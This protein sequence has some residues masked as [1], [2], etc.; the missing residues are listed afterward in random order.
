VLKCDACSKEITESEMQVKSGREVA[1]KTKAGF[2]PSRI[3]GGV[4][5]AF[6]RSRADIW[7]DTV[8]R[9]AT[10]EWG[11]CRDCYGQLMAFGS[12][13]PHGAAKRAATRSA[14]GLSPAA[15]AAQRTAARPL[16]ETQPGSSPA[17]T[18]ERPV[19][20]GPL[21]RVKRWAW[22]LGGGYIALMLILAG[23]AVL[24][25][26]GEPAVRTVSRPAGIVMSALLIV[27]GVLL[28][29]ASWRRWHRSR[30]RETTLPHGPT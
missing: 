24:V 14:A 18:A 22:L 16:A 1:S 19:A 15:A 25:T 27:L 5:S 13:G 9:N 6:G 20:G 29:L 2:V 30:T 26:P 28:I 10:A 21:A 12:R 4:V 8:E 17:A 3:A 11:F 7:R 23:I